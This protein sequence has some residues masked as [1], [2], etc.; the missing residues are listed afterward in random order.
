MASA[1]WAVSGPG[2]YYELYEEWPDRKNGDS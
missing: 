2:N 1:L